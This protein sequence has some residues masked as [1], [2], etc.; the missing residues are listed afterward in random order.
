MREGGEGDEIVVRVRLDEKLGRRAEADSGGEVGDGEGQRPAA[1]HVAGVAEE[2]HPRVRPPLQ[3]RLRHRF[4][5][6]CH[7]FSSLKSRADCGGGL[8]LDDLA[9]ANFSFFP[10]L[11]RVQ[12]AGV[13]PLKTL[14]L[15]FCVKEKYCYMLKS[16]ADSEKHCYMTLADKLKRADP[17]PLI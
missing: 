1:V 8:V 12:I 4:R 5:R 9:S 2:P 17:K 10:F 15:L 13:G 3:S 14:F 16:R 7:L 6:H 11:Q